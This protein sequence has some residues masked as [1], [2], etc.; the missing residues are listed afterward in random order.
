M[1]ARRRTHLEDLRRMMDD[2]GE[3]TG[4]LGSAY[5]SAR[6]LRRAGI[7]T[8]TDRKT[9]PKDTHAAF[10]RVQRAWANKVHPKLSLTHTTAYGRQ[11]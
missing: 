5:Q 11:R 8:D 9:A 7:N 4:P 6:A 10:K 1:A 2:L 3:F